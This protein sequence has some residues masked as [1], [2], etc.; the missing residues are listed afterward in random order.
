MTKELLQHKWWAIVRGSRGPPSGP[1]HHS[2]GSTALE[3]L[4]QSGQLYEG[5]S[6]SFHIWNPHC[7]IDQFRRTFLVGS[8]QFSRDQERSELVPTVDLVWFF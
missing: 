2:L 5:I 4:S 1:R 6:E 7:I 3:D 8:D